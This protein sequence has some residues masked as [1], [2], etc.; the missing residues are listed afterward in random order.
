MTYSRVEK[1]FLHL[2]A[3]QSGQL[4]SSRHASALA[5]CL[6]YLE[7]STTQTISAGSMTIQTTLIPSEPSS[8]RKLPTQCQLL[9]ASPARCQKRGGGRPHGTA[10]STW[11]ML[12]SS[13]GMSNTTLQTQHSQGHV[14]KNNS[15]VWLRLH[16]HPWDLLVKACP[17]DGDD[18]G[19]VLPRQDACPVQVARWSYSLFEVLAEEMHIALRGRKRDC[20]LTTSARIRDVAGNVCSAVPGCHTRHSQ[21]QRRFACKAPPHALVKH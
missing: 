11:H 15:G 3:Q 14:L 10:I 19:E 6:V 18:T 17:V 21:W 4:A 12:H 2:E 5:R 16:Q 13:K 8:A 7:M 20:G 1:T 9:Q